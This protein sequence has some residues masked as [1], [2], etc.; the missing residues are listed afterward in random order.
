MRQLHISI[1]RSVSIYKI[2]VPKRCYQYKPE[3]V[4]ILWNTQIYTNRELSSNMPDI[5]SDQG[6]R[7]TIRPKQLD[8]G[9]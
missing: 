2:K 6:P 7:H 3:T 8:K 9:H 5:G 1:E 4:T